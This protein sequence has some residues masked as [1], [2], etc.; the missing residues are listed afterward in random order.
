MKRM[1]F[2]PSTLQ[3]DINIHCDSWVILGV[4]AKYNVP[5]SS[6]LCDGVAHVQ[7]LYFVGQ[8]EAKY[9]SFSIRFSVYV[10]MKSAISPH[11][12]SWYEAFVC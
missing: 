10:W 1:G 2:E 7:C 8:P 12:E 4:S 6:C 3:I 11:V 9:D 5:R